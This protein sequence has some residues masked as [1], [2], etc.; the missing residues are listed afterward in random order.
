MAPEIQSRRYTTK[1]DIWSMGVIFYEMLTGTNA[2]LNSAHK[3]LTNEHQFKAELRDEGKTIQFPSYIS[4]LACDLMKKTL[5]K[6][7]SSRIG[8]SQFFA[9]PYLKPQNLSLSTTHLLVNKDPSLDTFHAQVGGSRF[10]NAQALVIS[11]SKYAESF[12][13]LFPPSDSPYTVRQLQVA[14]GMFPLK[15]P[16]LSSLIAESKLKIP[17]ANQIVITDR[18]THLL[19][20]K[21]LSLYEDSIIFVI[22]NQ[23][24]SEN[25]ELSTRFDYQIKSEDF[26]ET[27]TLPSD[28]FGDNL[29][30]RLLDAAAFI[31]KLYTNI[32]VCS[33]LIYSNTLDN[34]NHTKGCIALA[35]YLTND[36][37][38]LLQKYE[39]LL[40]DDVY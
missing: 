8:W 34:N 10:Y 30:K 37:E 15:L 2:I 13:P 23:V 14:I 6:R 39:T 7:P 35:R 32:K 29:P 24:I 1:C 27:A 18:G 20:N 33:D 38:V 5:I 31:K 19:P 25:P 26:A 22:E 9:H 36:V 4:D 12:Q 21:P 17:V 40:G 16:L 28:I 3:Q 11:R